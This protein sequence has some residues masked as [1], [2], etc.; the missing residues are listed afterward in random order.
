MAAHARSRQHRERGAP[1][2]ER[3]DERALRITADLVRAF[4]DHAL[5]GRAPGELLTHPER[6]YVELRLLPN[7]APEVQAAGVR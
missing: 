7:A 2:A 5:L 1:S 6:R 3:A 4:L